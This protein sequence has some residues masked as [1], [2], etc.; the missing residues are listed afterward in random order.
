MKSLIATIEDIWEDF[1]AKKAMIISLEAELERAKRFS[2][3][4]GRQ[5]ELCAGKSQLKEREDTF[6]PPK[7]TQF[8]QDAADEFWR[9]WNEN[10]PTCK[11]GYYE[12]TW[13]AIW[14]ALKVNATITEKDNE[15]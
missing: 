15:S 9:V 10:G 3:K 4:Q 13:M 14:A 7:G 6:I 1:I 12:S 11:H 8:S 5:L 2:K